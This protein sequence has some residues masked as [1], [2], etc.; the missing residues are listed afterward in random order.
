MRCHADALPGRCTNALLLGG[1]AREHGCVEQA[2]RQDS[3]AYDGD[4]AGRD[5]ANLLL[6]L[7]GVLSAAR[8]PAADVACLLRD[9]ADRVPAPQPEWVALV[10]RVVVRI[11][12]RLPVIASSGSLVRNCAVLGS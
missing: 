2:A 7:P 4:R 1:R 11:F 10:E 3:A 9:V 12:V 6:V 5:Q 8:D